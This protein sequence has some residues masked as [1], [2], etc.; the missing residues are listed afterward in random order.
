MIA[1]SAPASRSVA[2]LPAGSE[3]NGGQPPPPLNVRP[4]RTHPRTSIMRS[5][6]AKSNRKGISP[7]GK[8][9]RDAAISEP[10]VQE[11]QFDS[12]RPVS[13]RRR[14]KNLQRET[15]FA[16]LH[17]A[18]GGSIP[19]NENRR[20]PGVISIPK[21]RRWYLIRFQ[22]QL[23]FLKSVSSKSNAKR[24][25]DGSEENIQCDNAGTLCSSHGGLLDCSLCTRPFPV[26]L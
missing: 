9:F 6:A 14:F 26:V 10:S 4:R 24:T 19:Q 17:T 5:A 23:S 21:R 18:G 25:L 12:R 3:K 7:R 22:C 2:I 1:G 13:L 20:L 11:V 16:G 8:Y 15:Q